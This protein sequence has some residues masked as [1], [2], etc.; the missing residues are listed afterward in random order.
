M[1]NYYVYVYIDPRNFEEFY[2]GKGK[3]SRK[4][5][6]LNDDSDSEKANRIA[7]I[8]DEGL[9]PII[10]VIAKDLSKK[11]ALLIE[12]TLL[13]KLGRNLTNISS[14]H[15]KNKF[16]PHNTLH[17]ELNNFDYENGIYYYV[18]GEDSKNEKRN[19]DDYRELGF[20]SA[21]QGVKYKNYI[22]GF[23]PGDIFAAYLRQNKR[24]D[25]FG[26]VGIGRIIQEAKPV[27]EVQIDGKPLID[28]DLRGNMY[29][30]I[31]SDELCEYVALVEWIRAV[32]SSEAKW[33][34]GLFTN[35]NIRTKLDKQT[36]TIEF[37]ENT[38]QV[39]LRELVA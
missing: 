25:G 28:Y 36:E 12:K 11:E 38:F 14:G 15:F 24:S 5:A 16:R 23:N 27:R 19:W 8:K 4:N 9:E 22:K 39:N 20:I 35:Q 31:E 18:V 3:G 13:W 34:P 26:Y 17:L 1:N 37:L 6:H 7:S 32:E 21:G 30:N 29:K 2:F 10:R 33:E